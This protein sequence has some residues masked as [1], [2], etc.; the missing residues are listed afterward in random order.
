MRRQKKV[1]T[2][3]ALRSSAIRLAQANGPSA[4]TVEDICADAGVSTRTFFNYFTCK[5]EAFIGVD[6]EHLA[7]ITQAVTNR[8]PHEAPLAAVADVLGRLIGKTTATGVW[9]EQALLLREYPAL[10]ARVHESSIAIVAALAAG[11]SARLERPRNDPYI[12]VVSAT[13]MSAYNVA[14]RIWLDEPSGAD[15]SATLD[16]VIAY[17][18]N[19]FEPPDD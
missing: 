16:S 9:R 13:A 15:P 1:A 18:R 4:I 8:P 3:T 7:A 11:L 19:G 5:D 12:Q 14:L 2:F 6:D 10:M 17:L